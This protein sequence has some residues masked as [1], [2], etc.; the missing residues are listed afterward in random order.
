MVA[1]GVLIPCR[2]DWA[3]TDHSH[4]A[5]L[6]ITYHGGAA[7]QIN[8]S[9]WCAAHALCWTYEPANRAPMRTWYP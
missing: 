8:K 3:C 7:R 6:D 2:A 9:P 1:E 4:R 5:F